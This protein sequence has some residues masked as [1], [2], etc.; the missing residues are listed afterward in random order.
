MSL[1][2]EQGK[3]AYE[4]LM[5]KPQEISEAILNELLLYD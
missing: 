4:N 3:E 1:S 2:R 5:L